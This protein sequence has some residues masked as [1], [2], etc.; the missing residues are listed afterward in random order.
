MSGHSKG[1]AATTQRRGPHPH[2]HVLTTGGLVAADVYGSGVSTTRS[3]WTAGRWRG[4]RELRAGD[5]CAL[6]VLRT[7]VRDGL[8]GGIVTLSIGS[9]G[10]EM[11]DLECA[12]KYPQALERAGWGARGSSPAPQLGQVLGTTTYTRC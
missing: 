12:Y 6:F 7:F 4:P 1:R 9:A 8:T 5:L 3:E 2:P 11:C 10:G